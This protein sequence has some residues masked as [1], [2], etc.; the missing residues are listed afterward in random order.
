ML[1]T[2]KYSQLIS[3]HQ[4]FFFQQ[5]GGYDIFFPF[6]P[7]SFLL[8]LCCMQFFSSDKRLQKIFFQNHPPP[9]PPVQEL[10]GRPLKYRKQ[11]IQMTSLGTRKQNCLFKIGVF[12]S[13]RQKN[14]RRQSSQRTSQETK[15][16]FNGLT[17]EIVKVRQS[18]VCQ[19]SFLSHMPVT[20]T[21]RSLHKTFAWRTFASL[22]LFTCLVSV[23]TYCVPIAHLRQNNP[24]PLLYLGHAQIIRYF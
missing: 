20:L 14:V 18:A 24:F 7:V 2:T 17:F 13:S 4:E 9:S 22:G 5:S 10:N 19:Q 3:G 8:H 15:V 16:Y 6:F 12:R 11:Q 1:N 21:C 23:G